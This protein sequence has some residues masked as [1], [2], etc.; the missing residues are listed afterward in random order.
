MRVLFY[1]GWMFLVLAFAAAAAEAIPR[2]MPGNYGSIISAYEL[3]YAAA[4]GNL[5]VAQIQVEKI[6]PVLWDPV[7]VG[8]L[9]LPAWFLFALPGVILVWFCRPNREMS[10]AD[11]QD[12]AKQEESLLLYDQLAREAKEAGYDDNDDRTPD[13]EGHVLIDSEGGAYP[14]PEDAELSDLEFDGT[15][16]AEGAGENGGG[17]GEK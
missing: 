10:E 9:A 3:W 2:T 6:S 7:L 17:D 13:H 11:R 15:E 12:L 8:I 14:D 1:L 5:V 16:G 4:P